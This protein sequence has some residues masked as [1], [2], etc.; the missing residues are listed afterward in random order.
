MQ[1]SKE[2]WHAAGL[3]TVLME[4]VKR[5]HACIRVLLEGQT[6][7]HHVF[8]REFSFLQLRMI[9]ESI[10]LGCLVAHGD[11]KATGTRYF[12][13][14][15]WS[16]AEIIDK[17]EKLHPDFFPVPVSAKVTGPCT[18]HLGAGPQGAITKANLLTLYGKC[19]SVLHRGT[20]DRLMSGTIPT[21]TD[22]P[23]IAQWTNALRDLLQEHVILMLGGQTVFVCE[24]GAGPNGTP[25]TSIGVAGGPSTRVP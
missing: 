7:F 9:C 18:S 15:L 5:R 19:G 17:L 14:Q 13:K 11:I 12:R 2:M 22:L 4:E 10:A 24:M 6:G 25:K 23:D 16:A 21:Q 3:Y 20:R 1:V 8:I